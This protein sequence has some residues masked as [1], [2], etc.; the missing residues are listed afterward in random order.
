MIKH[1]FLSHPR[2]VGESYPEHAVTAFR[3]GG[4]M[5]MGGVACMIHALVPALF[6]RSASDRVKRLYAQMIA[7]QPAFTARRPAFHEP[8]WQ[9]E[10]E[11]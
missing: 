3:F 2:S 8:E 4:T 10:Y 6:Q 5:V 1:L 9:I 11:I 7:R